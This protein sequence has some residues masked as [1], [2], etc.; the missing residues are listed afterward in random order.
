[1]CPAVLAG[2]LNRQGSTGID[3]VCCVAQLHAAVVE[4]T[5]GKNAE[6]KYSTVQNWYSGNEEGKGGIYNFVTK[7]GLC[8]GASS[9]ISWTQVRGPACAQLAATAVP[10]ISIACFENHGWAWDDKIGRW[11]VKRQEMACTDCPSVSSPAHTEHCSGHACHHTGSQVMSRGRVKA[12]GARETPDSLL[13]CRLKRAPPS[14]GSTPA[15]C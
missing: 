3:A 12:A 15:W 7:R 9:K 5:A 10:S 14:P 8:H 4:L 1:M 6:I 11:G 13:A 2:G